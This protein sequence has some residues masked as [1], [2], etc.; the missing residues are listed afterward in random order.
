MAAG[1]MPLLRVT[2][3]T[4]VPADRTS[5]RVAV[6]GG[7]S[8]VWHHAN[9]GEMAVFYVLDR[10]PDSDRS[11]CAAASG[12]GELAGLCCGADVLGVCAAGPRIRWNFGGKIVASAIAGICS[13]DS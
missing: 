5:D 10:N 9:N 3:L 11:A 8:G 6:C 13:R 12:C 7:V 4:D 1:E 2:D